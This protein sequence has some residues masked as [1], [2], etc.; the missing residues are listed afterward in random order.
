MLEVSKKNLVLSHPALRVSLNFLFYGRKSVASHFNDQSSR[1]K[2]FSA[3]IVCESS[4][5]TL[6]VLVCIFSVTG[7]L[8][9]E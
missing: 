3:G 5:Y 2:I 1:K 7:K 8:V 6:N 9:L 4:L